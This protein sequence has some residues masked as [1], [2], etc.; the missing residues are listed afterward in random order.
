M[1]AHQEKCHLF[2]S[3]KPPQVVFIIGV[4]ITSGSV[5]SLLGIILGSERNFEN[6]LNSIC[7]KVSRKINQPG[8]DSNG[9]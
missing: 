1:R 6:R 8:R 7:N 9:I 3:S 5:E 2:L 4:T